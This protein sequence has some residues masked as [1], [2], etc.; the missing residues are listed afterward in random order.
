[1]QVDPV[2]L[3]LRAEVADYNNKMAGAQRLTD[4]RLGA[5]EARGMAFGANMKKGFG[6][7]SAAAAGFV[8]SFGAQQLAQMVNGA[9]Q[10]SKAIQNLSQVANAGV[11]EFQRA[12]YAAQSVGVE[13]EKLADIYK[14]V[15]D[16]VG[17][18]LAT[19]GGELKDFFENIAPKVGVTADQ[20]ARLSGPEALQLY[21]SSLEKAGINQQQMTFYMEALADETTAL[22]P[23]LRNGGQGMN[24]LADAADRLGIVLS[25]D[26]IQRAGE[27][28]QKLND[29]KTVL[30]ARIAGA[31][32]DNANAIIGL[33]NAFATVVEWAGKAANAYRRFKLEQGLS[34][35]ENTAN[36]WATS[37]RDKATARR[38]ADLYRYELAKMD[39]KVDKTGSFRDYRIAG[40]EV[41]G[42][43]GAGVAA[44]PKATAGRGAGGGRSG[45]SALELA[46]RAAQNEARYLDE[47]ARIRVDRLRSEADYTG[48]I[49]AQFAALTAALDEELKSYMRQVETD[50]S[51]DAAKRARLISEKEAA[52]AAERQNA[53]Q[54]RQ[55]AITDRAAELEMAEMRA[56]ADIL[57]AKTQLATGSKARLQFE[58]DMLDLQDRLRKAE[59][60]RILATEATASSAWQAAK[61]ERDTMDATAGDRRKLVER[62]NASPLDAYRQRMQDTSDNLD[63]AVEG[64]VVDELE[65]FRESMRGAISDIIGTDDPFLNGLIDLL[66]QDL[67]L[68]PLADALS[69]ASSGSG[70]GVGGFIASVGSAIFG[71]ASGGYVAPGQMVRVNEGAS[72]GRVEGWLPN[73]GGKVIPLGQMDALKSG[74]GAK[75]YNITIDAS[76][77]I[78]PDGFEQRILAQ[79]NAQA[80]AMDGQVA[81]VVVKNMPSRMGQYERDGF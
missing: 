50:D 69:N 16:K 61:I 45:P 46:N 3:Q 55:R 2:I 44:M 47:L 23:L 12:A 4:Q 22:L 38:N 7:A 30:E 36:G 56:Q 51:I 37:D 32:A 49:E 68:K 62:R 76:N 77:S 34:L 39:G 71:R 24:Q 70:G 63:D 27:T 66:I 57:D 67:V 26:Q 72:S 9:L 11:E 1:M 15:N 81:Q 54:D 73:G 59:L 28:A 80:A 43:G 74:G 53:E 41:G 5:I 52:I 60:D 29:I 31:V 19:G 6:L 78:N 33:A 75:V 18:F 8:A 21:V 10:A 17:E 35:N 65:S 58:L 40:I 48:S 64:F 14:D 25:Q 42:G 13:S 20:F 79:A